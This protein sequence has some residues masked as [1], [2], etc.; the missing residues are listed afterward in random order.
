MEEAVP[1]FDGAHFQKSVS[2]ACQEREEE[3]MTEVD[4]I[5]QYHSLW[6]GQSEG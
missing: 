5:F 3:P 4:H 1:K 6:K 2:S